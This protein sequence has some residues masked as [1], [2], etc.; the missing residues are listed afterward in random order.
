M[1]SLDGRLLVSYFELNRIAAYGADTELAQE[2][3]PDS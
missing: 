2:S 3:E 1:L